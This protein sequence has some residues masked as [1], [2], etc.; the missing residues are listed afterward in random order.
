[1][2]FS[3]SAAAWPSATAVVRTSPGKRKSEIA[4]TA[5]ARRIVPPNL[6]LIASELITAQCPFLQLY[7]KD[8]TTCARGV[9]R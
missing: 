4:A 5:L 9:P 6:D 8:A 2:A 1:M 3:C 7:V